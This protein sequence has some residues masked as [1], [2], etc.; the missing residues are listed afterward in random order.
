MT[1]AKAPRYFISDEQKESLRNFL[2][3]GASVVG[4]QISYL[5]FDKYKAELG[6]DWARLKKI[7][8]AI[9][10]D[11]INEHVDEKCIVVEFEN[12]Y[13]L[14]FFEM[15]EDEAAALT[16]TI[17]KKIDDA[18]KQEERLQGR[19]VQCRVGP[20]PTDRLLA[21]LTKSPDKSKNGGKKPNIQK[22][23]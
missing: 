9:S 7:V 16:Q 19:Y 21:E 4:S 5:N 3:S 11:V 17:G 20:M 15:S 10:H 12:K 8:F 18:L 1:E 2:V 13:S 22:L 6:S 23:R 14:L